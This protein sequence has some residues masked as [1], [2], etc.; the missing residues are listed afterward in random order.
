MQMRLRKS[1]QRNTTHMQVTIWTLERIRP[2]K[3]VAQAV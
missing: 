2:L 1:T 3:S